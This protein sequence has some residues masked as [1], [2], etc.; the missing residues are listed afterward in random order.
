M[1]KMFQAGYPMSQNQREV[2]GMGD[3]KPGRGPKQSSKS[4]KSS[5]ELAKEISPK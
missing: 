5:V 1:N 2:A 4:K 3:K